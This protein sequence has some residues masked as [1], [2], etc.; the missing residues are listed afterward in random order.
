LLL[1][2]GRAFADL[3]DPALFMEDAPPFDG[4]CGALK[5]HED[6]KITPSM[7]KELNQRIPE[8]EKTW[9]ENGGPLIR[10]MTELLGRPYGRKEETLTLTLC[11][12][13]SPM[14]NPLILR[15]REYLKATAVD[16]P[17]GPTALK[18]ASYF[19]GQ[20]FHELIH[21]YLD[22]HFS[23]IDSAA[24]SPLIRAHASEPWSVTSHLHHLS[25]Q[26]AVYLRMNRK[27]ELDTIID[28]DSQVRG[29]IYKRAWEI[30][31]SDGYQKYIDE[32]LKYPAAKA[33]PT[34][35]GP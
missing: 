10:G 26:K 1:H 13:F 5:Q 16:N 4:A 33:A 18:P 15:A 28:L 25:I 17:N 14:S 35:R 21:R 6:Y 29:G 9:R 7:R 23:N 11:Q 2:S 32:L 3:A 31:N 19:V 30:V 27:A 20:V 22:R 8:F 34:D 12:W 24:A